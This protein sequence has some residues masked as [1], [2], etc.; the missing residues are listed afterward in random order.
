MTK[1]NESKQLIPGFHAVESARAWKFQV[2]RETAG[3]S[4]RET[5]RYFRAAAEKVRQPPCRAAKRKAPR[6]RV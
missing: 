4:L 2:A 1:Q 5:L 6:R 3:I